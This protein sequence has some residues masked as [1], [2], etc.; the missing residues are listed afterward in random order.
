MTEE[1]SISDICDGMNL[2]FKLKD[3]QLESLKAVVNGKD[4]FAVLPTGYGK[5]VLYSILPK[6]LWETKVKVRFPADCDRS[7]SVVVVIS[8]L[9]SLMKDQ[10]IN[11]KTF[12]VD[13]VYIGENLEEGEY[14][15]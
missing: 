14:L 6:L 1:N 2:P 11:I 3:L 10:V 15:F 4:L 7:S 12:G 5:T 13:C 8:P 9:V